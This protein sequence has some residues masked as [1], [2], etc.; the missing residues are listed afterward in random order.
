MN[1]LRLSVVFPAAMLVANVR[2]I[3]GKRLPEI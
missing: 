1:S 2:I 3:G